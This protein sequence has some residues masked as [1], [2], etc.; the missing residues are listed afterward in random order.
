[1]TTKTTKHTKEYGVIIMN[2]ANGTQTI[3][4]METDGIQALPAVITGL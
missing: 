1:L 2:E 3:Q 4:T